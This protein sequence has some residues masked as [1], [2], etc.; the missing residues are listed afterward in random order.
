MYVRVTPLSFDSARTQEIKRFGDERILPLVRPLPGFRRYSLALDQA[1][2]RGV[3][4]TE[5]DD[6]QHA[7]DFRTAVASLLQEIA[8]LGV[9]LETSQV[10]EVLVQA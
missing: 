2:G 8:D 3:T 7:Q 1:A 9:I 5:W 6:Q 10:Y 4:L